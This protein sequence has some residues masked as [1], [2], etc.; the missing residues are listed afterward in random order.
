M[1]TMASCEAI[2]HNVQ[3]VLALPGIASEIPGCLAF[4]TGSILNKSVNCGT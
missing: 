3:C 1:G 4:L 2:I